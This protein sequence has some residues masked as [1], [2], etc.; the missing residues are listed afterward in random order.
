MAKLQIST[1][2]GSIYDAAHDLVSKNDFYKEEDWLYAARHGELDA[3]INLLSRTNELNDNVKDI[4]NWDFSNTKSRIAALNN[5]LNSNRTDLIEKN[6]FVTD[7]FG[8]IKEEKFETTEY[9]YYKNAIIENNN[10][11]YDKYLRQSEQERKDS[12]NFFTKSLAT[13]LTPVTS[14]ASGFLNQLDN[15]TN[16]MLSLGH[17]AEALFKGEDISDT[18]VKNIASDKGRFFIEAEKGILN[19]ERK[20]TYLRDVNGNYTNFG[21]IIGSVGTSLGQM[22]PSLIVSSGLSNTNL[23]QKAVSGISSLVFYTGTTNADIKNTFEQLNNEN[24]TVPTEAI[25]LNSTIK[26][27]LQYAVELGLGKIFGASSLD[28]MVFG[29]NVKPNVAKDLTKAGISRLAEDFAEEGLEEV[30]QD[31]SDFLVDKAFSLIYENFGELS[32]LTYEGLMDSFI[33]GGIASFAGSAMK[34]INTKRIDTA[35]IKTDKKGNYV[36]SDDGKYVFKK[37][38]KL[39]SWEYGL[40]MQSFI[41]NFNE[42]IERTNSIKNIDV[43]SFENK[44]YNTALTEMYSAYRMLSSIYAEIGEERFKNANTILTKITNNINEGKYNTGFYRLAATELYNSLIDMDVDE[45][46]NTVIDKL[47]ANKISK[48]VDKFERGEDVNLPFSKEA[49]DNAVKLLEG[50][51][52]IKNIVITEDGANVVYTPNTIFVPLNYLKNGDTK[53]IFS[54]IAEQKLVEEI[55]KGKFKGN[56]LDKVL[57]TYKKV[58]GVDTAVIDEAVYNLIF[59]NSFFNIMLET[60]NKDMY[61]LLTSFVD[62][63]KSVISKDLRTEQYKLKLKTII[64]NMKTSLYNHCINQQ[65]ADYRLDI[66]SITEQNKIV[67]IRWSKDLYNRI[68][69]DKTFNKLTKDDFKILENRINYMPVAKEEKDKLLKDIKSNVTATRKNA[70]DKISKTY[71][72]LFTSLYDGKTYMPENSIPNMCFN[73]YLRNNN[74]TIKTL[75]DMDLD[76]ATSEAVKTRF[77]E[78]TKENLLKFRQQQFMLSNN[79]YYVFRF[80]EQGNLGIYEFKTNIQTGFNN[81]YSNIENLELDKKVI[82]T[83][84]KKQNDL[85]KQLLSKNID[86]TTAS[87]MDINDVIVNPNVLNEQVKANIQLKFGEINPYTT[88]NY[89]REYFVSKN[90]NISLIVLQD[91]TF[92]FGNTEYMNKIIDNNKFLEILKTKKEFDISEI[93]DKKYIK[94]RLNDLKVIISDFDVNEAGQYNVKNNVIFLNSKYVYDTNYLTFALLHEFQHAIQF[95]NDMNLG[96][97]SNWL[98]NLSSINKYIFIRDIKKHIPD[99]FKNIKTDSKEEFEIVNNL[100]YDASGEY[101][102]NGYDASLTTNFY[103]FVVNHNYET[104][105]ITTPWGTK[106][107]FKTGNKISLGFNIN[108]RINK[109]YN[110]ILLNKTIPYSL[111]EFIKNPKS[112]F[113]SEDG[114]IRRIPDGFKHE[115]IVISSTNNL[116]SKSAIDYF[117]SIPQVSIQNLGTKYFIAFRIGN[118]MSEK[119]KQSLLSIIDYFY[120][121]NIQ[122]DV[123]PIYINDAPVVSSNIADKSENILRLFNLN[124]IAFNKKTNLSNDYTMQLKNKYI[125]YD[126]KG[127]AFNKENIKPVNYSKKK[128]FI[129]DDKNT[130]YTYDEQLPDNKNVKSNE[131][132]DA[133]SIYEFE[134]R[135]KNKWRE[136]NTD[137]KGDWISR[138]PRLDKDG[139]VKFDKNNN[140]IWN[141]NNTKV[142]YEKLRNKLAKKGINIEETG[143]KPEITRRVGVKKSKGTNLEKYGYVKKELS[144]K[145]QKFINNATEEIDE[146]LW[147]LI[148]KGELLTEKPIMEYFRNSDDID[149]TTFKLINDAFFKNSYINTF[150]EL[151][152][153]IEK[154]PDYYALNMVMDSNK[155]YERYKINARIE[156]VEKLIQIFTKDE[157][158]RK[159]FEQIRDRYNTYEKQFLEISQ[160]NLRRLWMEKFNGSITR[161]GHL[162]FLAKKGAIAGW[163]IT[164]ESETKSDSLDEEVKGTDDGLT[165]AGLIA[166][167]S[168]YS[169]GSS[170]R[171]NFDTI[172]LNDIDYMYWDVDRKDKIDRIME[173]ISPNLLKSYLGEGK[174][175]YYILQELRKVRAKFAYMSPKKY[176]Q[177]VNDILDNKT[178]TEINELYLK[179]LLT[180][181]SGVDVNNLSD[182]KLEKFNNILD[183]DTGDIVK[184]SSDIVNNIKSRIRTIKANLSPNDKK[185]FLKDNSDIFDS[186][187]KLKEDAYKSKNVKGFY[188]LKESE[189][190]F[191]LF[192]RISELAEKTKTGA[193]KSKRAL[194]YHKKTQMEI[195]KL[196]ERLKNST[197]ISNNKK[198]KQPTVV[199]VEIDNKV[200]NINTTRKMPDILKKLLSNE[201]TKEVKSTTQYLTDADDTHIKMNYAT[202]VEN[203]AETLNNLTQE[204]ADNL[205]DYYTN[206]VPVGDTLRNRQYLYTQLYLS[207][208]LING[209]NLNKTFSITE[210]QKNILTEQLESM[211]SIPAALLASWKKVKNILKPE[212]YIM[213]K[214]ARS[215]GIEF[216]NADINMLTEAIDSGDINRIKNAKEKLYN[217]AKKNYKGNK[218]TFMDKF[219]EFERIAMLSGPGTWIRNRASNI[220]L[221]GLSVSSEKIG[222]AT[223]KLIQKM[224]PKNNW[225]R[226][227]QYKIIGTEVT[228]EVKTFIKNNVIDNGLLELLRDGLNKYDIR[229][230]KQQT[231]EQNLVDIVINKIESDIFLD[232]NINNKYVKKVYD[233][234]YKMMSDDKYINKATIKYLGKILTESNANLSNGL[235][236]NILNHI[237]E[238]YV[239]AAQEFMH[240]RNIISELE[241][242]LKQR[243]PK[244]Y[245]AYKQVFPFAAPAWNWFVEGLNYTP[246]GL[247]KSIVNYAK[248]EKTVSKMED[249]R[250][251]GEQVPSSKFAEYIAIKNI[252]KGVLGSV[253]MLIGMTLAILG[254]A[255]IDD[256]DEKYKLKVL[257]T[258]IDISDLFGT[259][260]ILM[261]IS[262]MSSLIKTNNLWTCLS[263]TLNTMFQD[264]IYSDFYNLF[265]Y[266]ETFTDFALYIP[267]NMLQ[268]M[269]PNFVKSISS[270]ASKYKVKYSSGMLGRIER[271]ANQA[272]PFLSYGLPHHIDP[273]T[274][275]KQVPYKAWFITN[276]SNKL[277][278]FK[279]QPYNVSNIE[280]EA[281]SLGVNKTM[282]NGRFTINDENVKLD[283]KLLEQLNLFYGKLNNIEFNKLKSNTIKYKVYNEKTNSYDE[284]IYNKMSDKQKATVIKRIMSDNSSIAKIYVLT[285]NKKYKYYTNNNEYTKLKKLGVNNNVHINNKKQGFVKIT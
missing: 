142:W 24:A 121:K 268:L 176:E 224:L 156:L 7:E 130:P 252:G 111:E 196:N 48:T 116:T 216:D 61:Q 170:G 51:K 150:K 238:A 209:N 27:G 255:D 65:N 42:L 29:R 127:M 128:Y 279:I 35:Q 33:V 112:I 254:F 146:Q 210:E 117:N 34:I 129:Y 52:S 249:L 208:F 206:S 232:T 274:G 123:G 230:G 192:V 58:S 87:Y 163:A 205:I 71:K 269:I 92:A 167:T 66:F 211:I 93:V 182:K 114:S 109:I 260:G 231:I 100:I 281:I 80:D 18:F 62:I 277:L 20:Y 199:A 54:T 234:I 108:D 284:L 256:E 77:G 222:N 278:P 95:E 89:L 2:Y 223:S 275:E 145:L 189:E 47:E 14:L 283:G 30:F 3:Y 264:S 229:K 8:K 257:G 19:F 198:S 280:K 190:L 258:N 218:R 83:R 12:M 96:M 242:K 153:Y 165:K 177:A 168:G 124:K 137:L 180:E 236:K 57:D 106:Y 118:N 125:S 204:E 15:L 187:L 235:D 31:T 44:K 102:A 119:S 17:S 169:T 245:F 212:E 243:N 53:Q 173:T 45:A 1:N 140:V 133:V 59:N 221:A 178:D 26:S 246:V 262:T 226:E 240:K 220:V 138:Y 161:A 272:I 162:T 72:N 259:Q 50:D 164:G 21:K 39:A 155:L 172:S 247:I 233:F 265:R 28:E 38:G 64:K 144:H 179:T 9:D 13:I 76:N 248:L 75:L 166:D 82:S 46:K 43:N 56:V 195:E 126:E 25:I 40:D 219:L 181:V 91:G 250:Q 217:N 207:T 55:V 159:L 110:E 98:K 41:T 32:E 120:A 201:F 94:G 202:F 85:V 203:N 154:S 175:K 37:L 81:F 227:K 194:E 147:N 16:T 22:L 143:L 215:T 191:K 149:D 63:E 78:L 183:K 113:I 158:D 151:E 282:L 5:E 186:K 70:M 237:A 67:S 132:R 11:E 171:I 79:K 253:G 141:Y 90:K 105:T 185:R 36:K 10:Y 97:D 273:Y 263:E 148:T 197:N 74:L 49:N 251:K 157:K 228:S 184:S 193:Y 239:L 101:Q 139:N 200:V 23:S 270:V 276:L 188:R 213:K 135:P 266:N 99:L 122:F 107:D 103:P 131:R 104:T 60:S 69:N 267:N 152:N 73:A 244:L 261:G 88:F 86:N 285:S 6:K 84:D 68:L 214:L 160:K 115:D 225:K 241:L 4:Y 174:E 271:L 134:K 136:Y